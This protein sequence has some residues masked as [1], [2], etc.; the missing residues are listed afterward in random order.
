MSNK[1][2]LVCP[3]SRMENFIRQ[4]YGDGI[5]FITAMAA[6]FQSEEQEYLEELKALIERESITEI[7]IANDTSCRFINSILKKENGFD[8]TAE[9]VLQEIFNDHYSDIIQHKSLHEQ[10]GTLAMLNVKH[11]A[12]EM[13]KSI[14]FQQNHSNKIKFTGLVTTKTSNRIKEIKFND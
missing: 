14:L 6:V 4:K 1:L 13:L 8:S 2:F 3:F 5:F 11:Q 12:N 9:K 7:I 10:Q